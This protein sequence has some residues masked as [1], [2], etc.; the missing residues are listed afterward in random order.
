M[1]EAML[2][3][4]QHG[5]RDEVREF[6]HGMPRQLILDMGILPAQGADMV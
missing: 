3:E 2:T 5:L 1:F 6:V 4:G